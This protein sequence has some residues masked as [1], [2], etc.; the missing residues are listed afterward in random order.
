MVKALHAAGLEVILDVVFNHTAEGNENGPTLSLRGF[1]NA[2][3]LPAAR[4]PRALREPPGYR[5]HD[6]LRRRPR[7]AQMIIDCLRYW[8]TEMHVD[9]FRFDLAPVLGARAGGFD[10]CAPVRGHARGPDAAPT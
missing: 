2:V 9:G 7:S 6:Q 8:A 1:D 5:Q 4:Q 10:R 3:V